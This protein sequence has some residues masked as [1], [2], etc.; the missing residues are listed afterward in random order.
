[1]P[2]HLSVS[3]HSPRGRGPGGSQSRE[4][5]APRGSLAVPAC[6]PPPPRAP[7]AHRARVGCCTRAG[8]LA[9]LPPEGP[10]CCLPAAAQPLAVDPLRSLFPALMN[11]SL[12][13]NGRWVPGDASCDQNHPGNCLKS[14]SQ[15]WQSVFAK[16]PRR[17]CCTARA[18]VFFT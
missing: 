4:E 3:Q 14:A 13:R 1:M 10:M 11:P 15:N 12:G 8:D 7:R 9:L 2:C 5:A 18:S 6:T 17:L 16:L